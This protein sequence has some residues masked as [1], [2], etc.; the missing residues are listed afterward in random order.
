MAGWHHYPP[1]PSKWNKI[2]HRLFCQIRQ[3]WRGRPLTDRLAVVELIAATTSK[4]GLKIESALDPRTYQKGIKVSDAE[5]ESLRLLAEPS[6]EMNF[7]PSGDRASGNSTPAS[8]A[9]A[10]A[11]ALPL[12]GPSPALVQ[13][14][15]GLLTR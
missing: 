10:A 13:L 6:H 14:S 4:A 8:A 7:L 5:M 11:G 1:G 3:N 9:A 12:A 15:L 2:K